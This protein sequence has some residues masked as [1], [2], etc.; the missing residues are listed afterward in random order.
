MQITKICFHSL[1]QQIYLYL[2]PSPSEVLFQTFQLPVISCGLGEGSM[3]YSKIF[4]R[5]ERGRV[6][7]LSLLLQYTIVLF[8]YASV[9]YKLNF[10]IDLYVQEKWSIYRVCQYLCPQQLQ[11][12][13]NCISRGWGPAVLTILSWSPSLLPT[14]SGPVRS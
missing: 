1:N 4:E 8:Y 2:S 13:W 5:Q 14:I 10:I 12:S 9:I 7:F 3:Q 6:A 11:K